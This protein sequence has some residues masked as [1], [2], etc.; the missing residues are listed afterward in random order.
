MK[1]EKNQD[2]ISKSNPDYQ[3][4]RSKNLVIPDLIGSNADIG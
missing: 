2:T 1:G 3:I 4:T